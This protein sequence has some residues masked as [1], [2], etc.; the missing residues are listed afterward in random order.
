MLAF[1]L[2]SKQAGGY[3]K[4]GNTGKAIIP[5]HLT[6]HLRAKKLQGMPIRQSTIA[7]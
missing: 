6:V 1:T 2:P 3:S 5:P 4:T 7:K